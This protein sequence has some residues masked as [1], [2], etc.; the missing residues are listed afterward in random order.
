[1]R[2]TAQSEAKIQVDMKVPP[3]G[4][5]EDQNQILQNLTSQGYDAIALSV[6]AP[7]DQLRILNEVA[8]K[9]NLITFDS[10]AE[11]SKRLSLH[12]HEQL[13]CRA[14]AR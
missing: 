10:D 3:N 2:F 4:A 12:R 13:R 7:K 11:K 8:E 9:T 6:I 5:P 14:G 1:M